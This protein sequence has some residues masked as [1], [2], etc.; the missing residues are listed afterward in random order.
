[1]PILTLI[2]RNLTIGIMSEHFQQLQ[3]VGE[4]VCNKR[5]PALIHRRRQLLKYARPRLAVSIPLFNGS[6]RQRI[7][8]RVVIVE[9]VYPRRRLCEQLPGAVTKEFMDGGGDEA[10]VVAAVLVFIHLG[11]VD[12][13]ART[14]LVVICT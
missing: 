12:V 11:W 8:G 9:V 1:M 14:T 4:V 10:D 2:S 13:I 3:V 5:G 7:D 6:P